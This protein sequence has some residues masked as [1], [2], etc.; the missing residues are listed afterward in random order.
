MENEYD[1]NWI[2]AHAR[3]FGEDVFLD[4]FKTEIES[5]HKNRLDKVN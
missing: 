4:R 1:P 2:R 3:K 5:V